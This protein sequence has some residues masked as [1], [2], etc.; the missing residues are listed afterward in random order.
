MIRQSARQVYAS[1]SRSV[2]T[3]YTK[4]KVCRIGLRQR[5][6][7]QRP[8]ALA[9]KH[10]EIRAYIGN[11]LRVRYDSDDRHPAGAGLTWS[12]AESSPDGIDSGPHLRRGK[13]V[14]DDYRRR[15]GVITHAK[16]ATRQQ[17]E[18]HE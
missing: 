8:F 6:P 1:Q 13:F 7:H 16:L 15:G 2:R 3:S 14:K 10:R 9:V 17:L 5:S 18:S 4:D 12:E 11:R